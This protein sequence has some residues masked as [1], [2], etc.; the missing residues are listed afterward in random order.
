MKK[1][2]FLFKKVEIFALNPL[3]EEILN[4]STVHEE[5]LGHVLEPNLKKADAENT[6][7]WKSRNETVHTYFREVEVCIF[8]R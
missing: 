1:I 7:I 5:P 2:Q 6:F 4:D 3:S 8:F